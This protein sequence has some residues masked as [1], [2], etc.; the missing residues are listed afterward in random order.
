MRDG[1][2]LRIHLAV[3]GQSMEIGSVWWGSES[4]EG[5]HEEQ[6]TNAELNGTALDEVPHKVNTIVLTDDVFITAS[7]QQTH[8]HEDSDDRR[9]R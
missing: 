1:V 8:T 7:T 5:R 6:G 4:W 3:S 9:A 2:S